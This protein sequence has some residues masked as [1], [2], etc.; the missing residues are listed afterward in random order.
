LYAIFSIVLIIYVILLATKLQNYAAM[1][2]L[3]SCLLVFIFIHA[4]YSLF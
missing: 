4:L 3:I 1:S 2:K